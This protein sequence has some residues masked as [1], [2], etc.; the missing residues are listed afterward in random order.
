MKRFTSIFT[1]VAVALTLMMSVMPMTVFAAYKLT[2]ND[3]S[4]IPAR[5]DV[6]ESFNIKVDGAKVYFY[7]DNKE[8]ATVGKKN[9]LLTAVGPGSVKIKGVN[10]STGKTIATKTINVCL[11]AT[12]VTPSESEIYLTDIGST[13]EISVVLTPSNS[14][15]IIRYVSD[16]KNVATVNMKTG[17]V[18]AEGEGTATITIYSKRTAASSADNEGTLTATVRVT[19]GKF[20]S[21]VS[22]RTDQTIEVKFTQGVSS[23]TA[24]EL[25]LQESS[26]T[27]WMKIKCV[28]KLSSDT[29]L[30]QVEPKY[31]MSDKK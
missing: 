1:A 10:Q 20:L 30:I 13:A 11:R 21:S 17:V 29:Y 25:I 23:L 2:K 7:S 12:S 8:V 22:A 4:A 27:S 5:I 3:G 18:T 6:G 9:G 16:N 15:D 19:V 24:D 14:T 26:A 31:K 28:T